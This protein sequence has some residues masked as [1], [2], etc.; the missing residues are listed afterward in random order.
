MTDQSPA[1]PLAALRQTL[2]TQLAALDKDVQRL[3]VDMQ[4]VV[5]DSQTAHPGLATLL[6]TVEGLVHQ[7]RRAADASD[8]LLHHATQLEELVRVA[9]LLNASLELDEV[10]AEV[11]DTVITLTGAE[12][13][14]IL[15]RHSEG[16]YLEPR[17]T[18]DRDQHDIDPAALN[19]SRGII[20]LA[21]D[22]R[23][24]VVT[25]NAQDDAR[26][27]NLDSVVFNELRSVI[28]IPLILREETLG[29]LYADHRLAQGVFS[30]A[31]FPLL[32]AFANQAAIAI[33][34]ARLFGQVRGYL[35][36]THQELLQLSVEIDHEAVAQKVA[37]IT[38]TD[39]FKKLQG[40]KGNPSDAS[41]PPDT[42]QA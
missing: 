1:T 20:Q 16:H 33:T 38:N 42:G 14:S 32:T 24:P 25:T 13:A 29:V 40:L 5:V 8:Q 41:S 26:F 36:K 37:Q 35:H 28:V 6:Q 17:A 18:R 4:R 19:I 23:Q 39:V 30:E 10:L 3:A 2:E 7:V 12:R 11:L 31:D 9:S 34:N 27:E 22:E 21:L 15:L